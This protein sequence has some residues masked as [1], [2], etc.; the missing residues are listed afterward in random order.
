MFK[1][2]TWLGSTYFATIAFF[3]A[4]GR[5]TWIARVSNAMLFR[6]NY[7]D[8][9][10]AKRDA[11]FLGNTEETYAHHVGCKET[12]LNHSWLDNAMASSQVELA[13]GGTGNRHLIVRTYSVDYGGKP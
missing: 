9:A 13:D 10:Q 11:D 6:F 7:A 8:M 12:I 1:T 3:K 4:A 2:R 5:E